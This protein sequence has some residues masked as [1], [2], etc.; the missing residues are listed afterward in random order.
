MARRAARLALLLRCGL[1]LLAVALPTGCALTGEA[2]PRDA[3]LVYCLSP[4]HRQDLVEAAVILGAGRPA[5]VPDQLVVAGEQTTI[6]KWRATRP[7]DFDRACE[8]LTATVLP[9]AG[10]APVSPDAAGGGTDS[11][12]AILLPVVV[13]ALLAWFAAEWRANAVT[14]RL[15]ADNLVTAVR[16]YARAGNAH[17]RGWVAQATGS[18]RPDDGPVWERHDEVDAQ[19]RRCGLRHRQ[20]RAPGAL[21][22]ELTRLTELTLRTR[23][24]GWTDLSPDRRVVHADELGARL[25]AFEVHAERVAEAMEHPW[26]RW[27]EMRR[28]P[29]DAS[30]PAPPS[31]PENEQ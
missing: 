23:P 14:A 7:D 4:E 25:A 17:A 8:A 28:H 13:G 31:T 9:S 2:G 19:F 21:R 24:P 15:E 5:P 3:R 26:R 20:W 12:T 29:V 30:T 22:T 6:E 10:G 1:I 18:P 11:M 27:R 16:G